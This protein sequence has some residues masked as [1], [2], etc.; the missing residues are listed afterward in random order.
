MQI[1]ICLMLWIVICGIIL[2]S[3]LRYKRMV[4]ILF[5]FIPLCIV[6]AAR[7]DTVG[8]DTLTYTHF[9]ELIRNEHSVISAMKLTSYVSAPVYFAYNYVLSRLF[10]TPQA[11]IVSNSILINAL[12]GRFIYKSTKYVGRATALFFFLTLY[13]ESMNG[14]R[15]FIAI[16]LC[17][18]AY[19]LLKEDLRS[20][21]GWIIYLIAL[22]VHNTS[23]I[24]LLA[25]AA[26]WLTKKKRNIKSITC[27]I[28]IGCF[29]ASIIIGELINIF[30]VI[31]PRYLSY[32]NGT[33][34]DQVLKNT[35]EGRIA[36]IFLL[37]GVYC[38]IYYMKKKSIKDSI[39]SPEYIISLL[40]CVLGVVF[41]RNTLL[42][43]M[44]W[45]LQSFNIIFIPE[46]AHM[47]GKKDRLVIDTVF[48]SLLLVY[49]IIYLIEGKGNI[50][51]FVLGMFR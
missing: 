25:I 43:R 44:N 48:F 19:I 10:A 47:L 9:F 2:K 30:I 33:M 27:F 38:Y 21:K 5:T 4:Y 50:S 8:S 35:G 13:F 6:S 12:I 37:Q 22:G 51:P 24:F 28:M 1:Y 49:C 16:G 7:A 41:A 15:Q 31:F 17:L 45:Y 11:L 3:D 40:A 39:V 32:L 34:N 14:A 29:A 18:N 23:A 46:T 26:I 42:I 20:A 36:L